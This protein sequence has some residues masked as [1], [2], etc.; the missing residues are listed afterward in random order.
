M[1]V[2]KDLRMSFSSP[3]TPDGKWPARDLWPH[4][5][6]AAETITGF[7]LNLLNWFRGREAA[8]RASSTLTASGPWPITRQTD[9]RWEPSKEQCNNAACFPH[10]FSLTS[11]V[12]NKPSL[13]VPL[14][15]RLKTLDCPLVAD[16]STEIQLAT[17]T[18]ISHLW[19]CWGVDNAVWYR[20]GWPKTAVPSQ[21]VA[22][23]DQLPK[24]TA[25]SVIN[26]SDGIRGMADLAPR[27]EGRRAG[28]AKI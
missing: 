28:A 18:N 21:L 22:L 8:P 27:G 14:N 4:Q 24:Q 9:T 16:C 19:F 3:Q 5:N 7:T 1:I 2:L 17:H 20:S 11:S 13:A 25:M 15:E 10:P 12:E 26:T 6:A 23:G